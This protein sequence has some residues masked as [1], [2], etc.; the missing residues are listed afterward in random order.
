MSAAHHADDLASTSD[1]ER[2]AVDTYRRHGFDPA[3]PVSPVRLARQWLGP[4]A[5]TT[6]RHSAGWRA[7]LYRVGGATRIAVRAGLPAAY[8]RF[9][10][11]HELAHV[12]LG[13]GHAP[14][15]E[16]ACDALAAALTAPR[17]AVEALRAELGEDF[18][19]HA[20]EVGATE[21]WAAL[22]LAEVDGTPR[23]VVTPQRVY[24]VGT[25]PPGLEAR[26]L[27]RAPR[28]GVVR[29][30]LSDDPRRLVL[31]VAEAA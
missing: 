27:A 12:L 4:H 19:A 9:V 1:L 21:T 30:A 13:T 15:L 29:R 2:L 6:V 23:A 20:A 7:M 18:A 10:V 17:P 14:A 24:A 22:R 8:A 26:Q 31:D 3:R 11:A 16:R 28:R 5:V 25:W